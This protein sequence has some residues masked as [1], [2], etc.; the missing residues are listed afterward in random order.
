MKFTV[1][2]GL[3]QDVISDCKWYTG[4]KNK[5]VTYKFIYVKYHTTRSRIQ[6]R[7]C[8]IFMTYVF[9]V[10][11]LML[12]LFL[13]I[14]YWF[15]IHNSYGIIILQF[16]IINMTGLSHNRDV[17][18]TYTPTIKHDLVKAILHAIIE[19]PIDLSL[20][21]DILIS[22]INTHTN[23]LSSYSVEK[24]HS[25]PSNRVRTIFQQK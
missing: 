3:T 4:V 8:G 11:L 9:H 14:S 6:P 16:D 15:D 22:L 23:A 5:P 13:F 18:I 7:T 2:A 24:H 1:L 21:Y 20:K 19:I 25:S 10:S 12:F 17:W